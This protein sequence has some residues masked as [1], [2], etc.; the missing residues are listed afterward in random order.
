MGLEMIPKNASVMAQPTLA[1]HI[2]YIHNLELPP[3]YGNDGYYLSNLTVYWFKPTYIVMDKNLSDYGDFL[4]SSFNVYNYM[5]KN[6]TLYYNQ[7]GFYIYK[8]IN[9]S[10]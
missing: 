6:Y 3:I 5:D 2:F 8:R 10:T 1:L 7:S 4:N 9:S